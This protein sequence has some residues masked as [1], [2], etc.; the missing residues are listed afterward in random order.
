MYVI[1]DYPFGRKNPPMYLCKATFSCGD[2]NTKSEWT[3]RRENAI[4]FANREFAEVL[5]NLT[6]VKGVVENA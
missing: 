4:K 1:A 3:F 6:G 2:F 5:A